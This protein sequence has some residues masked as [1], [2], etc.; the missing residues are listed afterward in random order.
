VGAKIRGIGNRIRHE[1]FRIDDAI[2]SEIVTTDTRA[3]KSALEAMLA[4]HAR[5]ST[6]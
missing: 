3:L 2:L 1:Y 6:S 4:R 5:D